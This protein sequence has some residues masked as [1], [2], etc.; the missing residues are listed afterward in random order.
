[1]EVKFWLAAAPIRLVIIFISV[2]S[3][4]LA[5]HPAPC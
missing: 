5:K 1:M 4:P 3:V 2:N